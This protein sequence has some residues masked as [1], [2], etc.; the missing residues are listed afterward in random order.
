[1]KHCFNCGAELADDVQRCGKCMTEQTGGARPSVPEKK[2]APLHTVTKWTG[3][4]AL[5]TIAYNSFYTFHSDSMAAVLIICALVA[6]GVVW[7]DDKLDG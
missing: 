1:M 2:N 7:M 4:T 6:A 3:L 5:F